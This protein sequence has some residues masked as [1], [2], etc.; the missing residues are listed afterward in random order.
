[1][2]RH[3]NLPD[4]DTTSTTA[5]SSLHDRSLKDEWRPI[6]RHNPPDKNG[7]YKPAPG[8]TPPAETHEDG[9]EVNMNTISKAFLE[10]WKYI[11]DGLKYVWSIQYVR[12]AVLALAVFIGFLFVVEF[13]ITLFKIF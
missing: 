3:S 12:I 6:N 7:G 11:S 5:D 8:Q 4:D 9:Q 10:L 1:M 2:S 13:L